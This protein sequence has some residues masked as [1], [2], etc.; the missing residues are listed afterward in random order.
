MM[1]RFFLFCAIALLV[2]GSAAAEEPKVSFSRDIKPILSNKCFVCHGP[3]EG[4][5]QA[6]LRLDLR[7]EAVPGVIKPGDA[8]HSEVVVRIASD[9]ADLRMPPADSK[10]EP[11]TPEEIKLIRRWI[12][13]GAEYDVHWAYVT[14]TR[15][16]VPEVKQAEWPV[17]A[18]DNFILAKLEAKG[19][20]PS[21]QADKRTLLRRLSLDVTGLPPK[22]QE[23]AEFE[24]DDSDQAYEKVVDRLLASQHFGERMAVYWLDIVRYADTGGYHSDNHRDVWAYRDYVIEAFNGNKPF[25]QFT[26]EQLAGDLLPGA[27]DEQR[28]ASGFNRLLQTTEEGG[29]QPKEYTAKYAADRVRNTSVIWLASTMGCSECHSHKYDPFTHKD[30]YSFAAFFADVNEKAVGRQDQTK[31]PTPEQASALAE[32]DKK[33]AAARE[34]YAAKTPELDAAREKWEAAALADPVKGPPAEVLEAIKVEADKRTQKQKQLIDA[35]F[36][37]HVPELAPVRERLAAL[38]KERAALD[39]SILSTLVSMSVPPRTIR[40]LPR[41]NWLDDSGE[42]V[43]PAIPEFLADTVV[44]SLRERSLTEDSQAAA[45][46]DQPADHL[47]KHLAG[48]QTRLDLARWIASRE[49]PLTARVLVNRLWMLAFGRGISPAVEDFGTQGELPTHPELLDWLAVEFV[50]SGWDVKHTFKLMLMSRTYRQTSV[51]LAATSGRGSAAALD[52]NN[53]LFSRQNRF[54]LDAEF[55]RDN[56]L[57]VSGILVPKIG[58]PSVK[59]YQPAG[60]WQYLNFPKREWENDKGEGLY[61]R[62]LYT[63]WQRTFLQPSLLA[64][65]ASSREE[66]IGLRPRTS[67]PQQALVLLNDPTYVEAARA[68]AGRILQEGGDS[69]AEQLQFAFRTVLTRSP[70]PEEVETLT[71]LLEKHLAEFAQEPESAREFLSVGDLKSPDTLDPAKLAAWTN[72][73]RVLLNLHETITR[74]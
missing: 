34:E 68:L 51:P 6:E 15:P 40:I 60:Y 21:P 19:I 63:Y 37:K 43:Q 9:D 53:D 72:V 11:L 41:G 18:I 14:P 4:E 50:E 3:D 10:K 64:F 71:K 2:A 65:D 59:P 31:L 67:T 52:P 7:D 47:P 12:D 5:R 32:L 30:F 42:I 49:N 13:E 48:R 57:A 17:N 23:L 69:P 73:S 58:G 33:L 8:E 16:P 28:I 24:A 1:S 66:C 61:R 55:I 70:R 20:A 62:G 45:E 27:T 36:R 29:A 74:N 35:E 38:E 44:R 39:A 54:R 22:P 26:V 56:A 46:L 25:D